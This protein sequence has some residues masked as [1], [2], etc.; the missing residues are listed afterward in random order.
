MFPYTAEQVQQMQ[1]AQY[2]QQMQAALQMQQLQAAA[3]PAGQLQQMQ[4]MQQLQQIQQLQAASAGAQLPQMQMPGITLPP[5]MGGAVPGADNGLL[6]L[7]DARP[8]IATG[9]GTDT[10]GD[11]KDWFCPGCADKQFGKNRTC[12][13]CSTSRDQGVADIDLVPN[14]L[15]LFLKDKAVDADTIDQFRRLTPEVQKLVMEQGGLFTARDPTAVLRQRMNKLNRPRRSDWYC[16]VCHDLQFA[17]NETCRGCGNARTDA[18]L[19]EGGTP[20]LPDPIAFLAP[21]NI[22]ATTK[23]LFMNLEP[24]QQAAVISKGALHTARDPTAVLATRMSQVKQEMKAFSGPQALPFGIAGG[25]GVSAGD[26]YCGKCH[27][28]QFAKN[29]KCRNCGAQKSEGE[30]ID[31]ATLQLPDAATFMAAFDIDYNIKERMMNLDPA[32]QA[33]VIAKGSLHTARD[34]TAVL[35]SR[36]GQVQAES[37]GMGRRDIAGYR[38]G[39]YSQG[40]GSATPAPDVPK[41]PMAANLLDA[42][43]KAL[44]A[45]QD[46]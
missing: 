8:F 6:G 37:K 2:M 19:L 35:A 29:E 20:N 9:T 14:A 32:L 22:D 10:A 33:N 46:R 42:W 17:K 7:L 3:L 11:D 16:S 31:S 36:I 44:K 15:E 41:T 24:N 25:G 1:L 40:K 21:F 18:D 12:R 43:T 23:A 34:P 39:P 26:W 45:A 4:Q 28:L 13:N 5:G 38:P 27:D 30:A